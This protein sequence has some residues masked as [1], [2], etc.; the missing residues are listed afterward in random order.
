M[1]LAPPKPIQH[2][3]YPVDESGDSLRFVLPPRKSIFLLGFLLVWLAAWSIA[4][5]ATLVIFLLSLTVVLHPLQ[6]MF[7][8]WLLFWSYGELFTLYIVLWMFTGR[9]IIEVSKQSLVYHF[10][11]CKRRF[12]NNYFPEFVTNLRVVPLIAI[13]DPNWGAA[14]IKGKYPGFGD[15]VLMLDYGPNK[16]RFGEG[17]DEN[18]GRRIVNQIVARFPE[19]GK[20]S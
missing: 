1:Q 7:F 11:I 3:G 2:T 6:L 19:Y 5:C 20:K 17:I 16:Y 10:E 18:E 4:G 12:T 8:L 15:G 13:G 9:E 14:T